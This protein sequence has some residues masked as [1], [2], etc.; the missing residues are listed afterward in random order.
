MYPKSENNSYIQNLIKRVKR[1]G[2]F[3]NSS[4]LTL[5]ECDYLYS[6]GIKYLRLHKP[7]RWFLH[8]KNVLTLEK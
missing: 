2:Y 3:G 1:L 8:S 4:D 6:Q 7:Y 5:E